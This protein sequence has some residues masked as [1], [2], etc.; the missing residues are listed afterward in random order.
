MPVY[1]KEREKDLDEP[2]VAH[3]T[4]THTHIYK[5]KG[6]LGVPFSWLPSWGIP[7]FPAKKG[8]HIH[9]W[10]GGGVGSVVWCVNHFVSFHKMQSVSQFVSLQ[11]CWPVLFIGTWNGWSSYWSD[12]KCW[13][14]CAR[15][16]NC[17]G[18]FIWKVSVCNF[19]S[20]VLSLG[21][22]SPCLTCSYLSGLWFDSLYVHPPTQTCTNA[23]PYFH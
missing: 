15:K 19:F 7:F 16:N 13:L 5:Y 14:L 17:C 11:W 18:E 20:V 23:V 3:N 22:L 2:A 21:I 8:A 10:K 9:F 4:L 12:W 1:L 6:Q